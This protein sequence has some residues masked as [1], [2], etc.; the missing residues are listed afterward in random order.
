[1]HLPGG[2]ST[3]ETFAPALGFQVRKRMEA[4]L[5][6]LDFPL[7]TIR[8]P[9]QCMVF[10]AWEVAIEISVGCVGNLAEG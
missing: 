3:G 9:R 4:G 7:R 10:A 6:P 8:F 1:M 2:P 5:K